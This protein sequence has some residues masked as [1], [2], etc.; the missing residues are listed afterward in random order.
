M[1]NID[2]IWSRIVTHQGEVFH[3]IRGQAFE[4]SVV[5]SVLRPSTTNQNLPKAEFEKALTHVPLANTVPLQAL[6]GPSYLYAILM[7]KRIRGT[8]W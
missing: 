3:Q 2:T 5:Q 6:R 4:Y 1:P 8:D 7:D